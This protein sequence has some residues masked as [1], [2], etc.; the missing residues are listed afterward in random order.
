[1]ELFSFPDRLFLLMEY[2]PLGSLLLYLKRH[3]GPYYF[4]QVD[5]DGNMSLFDQAALEV[6]ERVANRND[7]KG[8]NYPAESIDVIATKDLISFAFQIS[9]GMEYLVSQHIIH[10]DLAARNVLV[11]ENKVVKIS[12]FGMARQ[13][14]VVYVLQNEQV[15]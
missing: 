4:N 6:L 2:C 8:D 1:M 14:Q 9:R 5:G 3:R 11:T 10:R 7:N 12:D 15:R 13:R